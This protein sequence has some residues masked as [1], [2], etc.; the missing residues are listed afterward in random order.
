MGDIA[1]DLLKIPGGNHLLIVVDNYS[2]WPKVILFRKTD[3]SHVTR[4]MAYLRVSVVTMAPHFPL[5]NLKAFLDYLGIVHLK[6]IPFWLQS[7]GQ[8][9][10]CNET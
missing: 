4:A 10:R 8:V 1:V 7:N 5:Q 3:A 2:C 6:G 9:E